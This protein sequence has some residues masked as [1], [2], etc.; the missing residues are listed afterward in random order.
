MRSVAPGRLTA[1]VGEMLRMTNRP[2]T[3]DDVKVAVHEVGP[4]ETVTTALPAT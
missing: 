4:L 2:P 1:Q 3:I